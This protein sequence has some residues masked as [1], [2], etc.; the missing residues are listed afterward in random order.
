MSLSR[1]RAQPQK[2]HLD[3]VKRI[4]GSLAYMPE[5]AIRFRTGEPDF[6]D[7]QD[8]EFDWSRNVYG[9]PKEIIPTDIPE[10]RGK[11]VTTVHYVGA[12]LHHDLVTGRAV[13]AILH[14]V[15]GTPTDWCSE[16]QATVET[17]TYESE[18][19]AA[20]IAVDQIVDLKYTLMYLG[21]PIRSKCF[22]FGDNKSVIKISTI[23]NSLLSKRHHISAYHRVREAIALNTSCLSGQMARPTQQTFSASTGS[24]LKSGL[25]LSHFYSEEERLLR[26]NSSQR[27]VIQ[28]P[29]IVLPVSHKEVRRILGWLLLPLSSCLVP[30]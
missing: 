1:Y 18:F 2:G 8:Q 6:S 19:V 16:R 5:G 20:R 21:V 27:G 23:P 28:I 3:R 17:A 4:F 12:N 26:S 25:Y 15:N 14:I 22:M 29:L 24:S 10:P 30:T 9:S 7:I 13:T 11:Y